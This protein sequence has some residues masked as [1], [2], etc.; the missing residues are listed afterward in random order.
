MQMTHCGQHPTWATA[1]SCAQKQHQKCTGSTEGKTSGLRNIPQLLLTPFCLMF[2]LH[3][4][5]EE[6]WKLFPPFHSMQTP[7]KG[8]RSCDSTLAL[9]CFENRPTFI[10]FPFCSSLLLG[11]DR[12][13]TAQKSYSN[14]TS[15]PESRANHQQ[16]DSQ[17][18][19]L[20]N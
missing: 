19:G 3:L 2:Q 12:R 4:R 18:M 11:G 14:P 10:F 15:Q 20:I 7:P 16:C 17:S 5:G 6:L 8:D 13:H 9:C 1:P